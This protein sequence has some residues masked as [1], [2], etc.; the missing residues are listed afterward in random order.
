MVSDKTEDINT[1]EMTAEC[2]KQLQEGKNEYRAALLEHPADARKLAREACLE[3][4]KHCTA[5][6]EDHDL[7]DARESKAERN[8][9]L[10]RAFLEWNRDQPGI[11]VSPLGVQYRWIRRKTDDHA[12]IPRYISERGGLH[13]DVNVAD[14]DV[15]HM[16]YLGKRLSGKTFF[17]TFRTGKAAVAELKSLVPGWREVLMF[18]RNGEELHAYIPP[19]VGFGEAGLTC[20]LLAKVLSPEGR[21]RESCT[22]S[23]GIGLTFSNGKVGPNE[24]VMLHIRLEFIEHKEA[25]QAG[26]APGALTDS[27][28]AD[29]T[30][31]AEDGLSK[32]S[33][34]HD[35]L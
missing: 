3:T 13:T 34:S 10:S 29:E 21:D 9:R 24:V 8:K 5:L 4:M 20:V 19:E 6:W 17:N 33:W 12:S 22:P 35:E 25:Q 31:P 7:P 18:M 30:L 11:S 28:A 26:P 23:S 2:K 1:L 27:R 15:V 16:H 14:T 32:N